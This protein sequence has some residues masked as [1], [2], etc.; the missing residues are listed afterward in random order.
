MFFFY[1]ETTHLLQG[2]LCQVLLAPACHH[3]KPHL[4][5]TACTRK[6][7]R[8]QRTHRVSNSSFPLSL[9]PRWAST[10]SGITSPLLVVGS[11]QTKPVPQFLQGGEKGEVTSEY[12][13]FLMGSRHPLSNTPPL[14]RCLPIALRL[15][16]QL[17]L[18]NVVLGSETPKSESWESSTGLVKRDTAH[19]CAAEP[20]ISHWGSMEMGKAMRK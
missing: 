15:T 14:L 2:L 6:Q 4:P 1:R 19:L 12:C 5:T 9:P 17:A 7:E 3:S 11:V 20:S 16:P 8:G 10:N 13:H 18:P